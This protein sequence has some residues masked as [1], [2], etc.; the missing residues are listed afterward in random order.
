MGKVVVLDKLKEIVE[1]ERG[2]GKKI[3]FTNGCFDLLHLGHIRYLQE[4]KR[5]GDLLIVAVNSDRSLR[6]LKGGDRPLVLQEERA[7]ILA[8]LSA[9]DYVA[10][11]DEDTPLEI[12]DVLKPDVLVKGAGYREEET[13]RKAIGYIVGRETVKAVGGEVVTIPE[14][15]GLSTTRLLEKI[16]EHER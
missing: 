1:I 9:V 7:E 4:A 2:R 6:E 10:I 12:I 3:V 14:V 15:K 8:A 5:R 13:E 11:F 16:R